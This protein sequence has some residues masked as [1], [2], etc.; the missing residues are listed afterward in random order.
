MRPKRPKPS[1]ETDPQS[2][3]STANSHGNL[4]GSLSAPRRKT[5]LKNTSGKARRREFPKR[6]FGRQIDADLTEAREQAEGKARYHSNPDFQSGF[7]YSSDFTGAEFPEIDPDDLSPAFAE[8]P[9]ITHAIVREHA[10]RLLVHREHGRK[11]LEKKLLQRELPQDL[12]A[13]VLDQLAEEGLQCDTRFAESYTRMRVDRGYG[14]NK[15]RA[16]LQSRRL[17]QSHIEDAIRDSGADWTGIASNALFKK[18]GGKK[19]GSEIGASA[20]KRARMQRFL[21]QRGFEAEQIRSAMS[22]FEATHS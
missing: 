5:T 19:F 11:E 9:V 4:P 15:V 22:D 16:D 3:K 12:I 10:M 13:S 18:F 7:E 17:E 2:G 8:V 14:A 1:S 6:E 21:Y 20:K